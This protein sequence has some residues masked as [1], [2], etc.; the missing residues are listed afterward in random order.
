MAVSH[1]GLSSKDA[2]KRWGDDA[3]ARGMFQNPAVNVRKVHASGNRLKFQTRFDA[4]CRRSTIHRQ[5]VAEKTCG[6]AAKATI[7]ARS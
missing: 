1:F 2:A 7:I 3:N 4:N 5:Q 6:P